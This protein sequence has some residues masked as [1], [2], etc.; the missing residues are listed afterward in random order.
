MNPTNICSY[1]SIVQADSRNGFTIFTGTDLEPGNGLRAEVTIANLGTLPAVFRLSEASASNEFPAG[2]L[3]LGIKELREDAGRRIFLGEIGTV[4]A[5]GIGLGRFEVG[6]SRTYRFT[7]LLAKD[8]PKDELERSA[9]A[10]Y[11][12]NLAP[13]IR[14]EPPEPDVL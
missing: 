14:D 2:R 8:T 4:P 5:S 12:W 7:V 3:A 11:E 9:G 1:G 13:G 10:I 6:E